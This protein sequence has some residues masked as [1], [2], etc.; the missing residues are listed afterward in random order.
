MI[1]EQIAEAADALARI[2][3]GLNKKS[4]DEKDDKMPAMFM[5]ITEV[6]NEELMEQFRKITVNMAQKFGLKDLS[7]KTLARIAE[8]IKDEAIDGNIQSL[9]TLSQNE[10]ILRFAEKEIIKY[11]TVRN[12][13]Q[14]ESNVK[15]TLKND[16]NANKD[17]NKKFEELTKVTETQN[18]VHNL[19]AGMTA[20]NV[21]E[22]RGKII[23]I[24]NMNNSDVTLVMFIA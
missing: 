24:V 10:E 8:K 2:Q 5:Q 1:E 20:D 6:F 7:P 14:E 12:E 4:E 18:Q 17:V 16:D 11:D 15:E 3:L 23:K 22:V 19:F 13:N 21:S 9:S